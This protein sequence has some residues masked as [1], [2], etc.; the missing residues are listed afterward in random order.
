MTTAA[1][2]CRSR[3]AGLLLP[4]FSIR[5]EAGW[6][7]GE[8]PDLVTLA[9]WERDAHLD[10]V[11]MLP[12]NEMASGQHSPYSTLSAMAVDPI[13][14]RLADVAEFAAEGGETSLGPD[15]RG[16]LAALR[17]SGRVDYP[18]V[19]ALKR[20]CLRAAFQRF[21]REHWARQTERARAFSAFVERERAWLDDFTLF[22]ALRDRFEGAAWWTWPDGLA[23]RR[24]EAVERIRQ[25]CESEVRYHAYLQWLAHEQWQAARRAA[26][27]VRFFGDL[28]FMVGAD[29]ADVWANADDFARDLTVGTPPDAFSETGQDWGLP[30][31]RWDVVVGNDF[32][33]LR[34]RAARGTELFDGYRIDHVI[35][36]YRTWVRPAEGPA[37]FTPGDEAEQRELGRRVLQV[38]LESGA[39][40]VAEDLGTVPDFL[41]P[42]LAELGVPGYKVLRWERAW[43]TPGQPFID[44]R[45]WSPL[46]VATTGTHDTDSLADWW[47]G[48]PHEERAALVALPPLAAS[49]I[50]ADQ[51]FDASVRDALLQLLY[52]SGSNLLVLPLQDVFG[53]R[54]R[55]NTPATVGA[56][57][58]SWRMPFPVERMRE[59]ED[60][61]ERAAA[62]RKMAEASGRGWLTDADKSD[63]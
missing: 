10:F 37:Y 50:R 6:G 18:A 49:G 7:I 56:E 31:Y 19:R 34:Q 24:S 13:Y 60:A 5:S 48:A 27:P 36:F 32:R 25:S 26:A 4:L 8:I 59:R 15:A 57:N 3:H 41:R 11:L 1:D 40:I 29:S 23:D 52:E 14:L 30:A 12:V 38:F 42:S 43:N 44:P 17:E 28:P 20:E 53:W 9:R 46:S 33:W 63:V 62:L 55:I 61:R 58:W 51:P 35:G 2:F 45:N 39:C 16:R 47:D 21:E 54:D 22:R